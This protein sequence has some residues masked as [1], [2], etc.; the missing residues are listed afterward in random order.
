MAKSDYIYTDPTAYLNGQTPFTLYDDD[1][2]FKTDAVNV[3]QWVAKR[4]GHPVMQLELNS[5]SIYATF[6]ES[7]SEYSTHINNYNIKNWM[8]NSYGAEARESGSVFSETGTSE[9][10]HPG[11]MG[12]T[13]A[14]SKQYG[15]AANVGGEIDLY[16]G[17]I[18]T[19]K[20]FEIQ[21]NK[22]K[23]NLF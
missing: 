21:R 16:S 18:E 20:G 17:E 14:L 19:P 8:W 7:I 9:P 22:I 6:E 2:T 11:N 15:Q 4:L 5:G 3:T 10:K 23:N 12:T 13:F 1:N